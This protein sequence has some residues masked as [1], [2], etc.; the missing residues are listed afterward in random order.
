M[1]GSLRCNINAGVHARARG[2]SG[3]VSQRCHNSPR[4]ET[5]ATECGWRHAPETRGWFWEIL[6]KSVRRVETR[7]Q[8][9]R[10]DFRLLA[11][12][13]GRCRTRCW[14]GRW[15]SQ[16][17]KIVPLSPYVEEPLNSK[18]IKVSYL[19]W[20]VVSVFRVLRFLCSMLYIYIYIWTFYVHFTHSRIW[21]WYTTNE[22]NN[23]QSLCSPIGAL[24]T[25]PKGLVQGLEDVEIRQVET[26]VIRK[27]KWIK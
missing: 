2:R 4:W 19:N 12:A 14:V 20:E 5:G 10:V 9:R 3:R 23:Q 6:K 17:R 21:L 26:V 18:V 7:H 25:I 22:N 8:T 13:L 27:I 15:K 24:G 16:N 1:H 11:E